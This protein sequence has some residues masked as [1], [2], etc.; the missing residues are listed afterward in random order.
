[1]KIEK[2]DE[3]DDYKSISAAPGSTATTQFQKQPVLQ[4]S[5]ETVAPAP[6]SR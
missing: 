3:P 4:T 5:L 1:M 6:A 2:Q